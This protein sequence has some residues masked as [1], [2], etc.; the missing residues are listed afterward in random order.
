MTSMWLLLPCFSIQHI[1]QFNMDRILIEMGHYSA[2]NNEEMYGYPH[3][4][5]TPVD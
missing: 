4:S 2:G 5:P 1:Y 3:I